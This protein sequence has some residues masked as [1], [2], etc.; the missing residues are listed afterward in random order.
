MTPTAPLTFSTKSRR[1]PESPIAWFMSQA[2]GNPAMISLAAGLVDTAS[3]PAEAVG[4]A[5][6]RLL[7]D[8]KTARSCL[9]YGTTN[10]YA[11]LRQKILTHVTGL[12]RVSPADL[13]LSADEV[14]I[15]TGSQQLLYV[16][17]EM[18]FDAGDIVITEAPSYFVY[19]AVLEGNGARV[20]T[21]PMDDEGMDIAALRELLERLDRAGELCKVRMIYTVDYFQNPTGLTLSAARRREMLD[22]VR[23]YAPRQRILI[24]ED[25]AYRELRYEGDEIPSI[26]SLDTTN[27][28]VVYAGT[29]SKPCSPGLKTGYALMPPD[30]VEPTIRLKGNHDFGSNNFSQYIL[31]EL[32]E[33]GEYHKQVV[34]LRGVYREKRDAMLGALAEE[35]GGRDDVSWTRPSGGM[36]VWLRMPPRILTSPDSPFTQACIRG[37]VMFVP[38]EFGHIAGQGHRPGS[39]ARLSFGDASPARI[40]EGI[41]RLRHAADLVSPASSAPAGPKESMLVAAG[42]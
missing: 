6:D 34:I 11:P 24:M 29:F 17:S 22:L 42:S 33:S 31:N 9:Q 14:V 30:L 21:V 28:F 7:A 37:G 12:D 19:H 35:F 20:E 10:G 3:L 27:E 41:R 15:G 13:R 36:F 40:R 2:L 1:T 16:L 8:P 4:T 26:K 18:L 23:S 25:A 5:V 32:M 38:G 39:E